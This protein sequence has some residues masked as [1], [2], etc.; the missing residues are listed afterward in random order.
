MKR[1]SLRGIAEPPTAPPLETQL[2]LFGGFATH[3]VVE[4]LRG[5]DLNTM[6]P[7]AAFDML[8]RLADRART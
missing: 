6:T 4:E 3:P 8:R 2:A 7:L 1:T 5:V